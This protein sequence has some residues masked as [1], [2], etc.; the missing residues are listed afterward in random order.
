MWH[1]LLLFVG[2]RNDFDWAPPGLG[3]EV[4]HPYIKHEAL[5]CCK[6]CGGGWKHGIH[7]KP[8]N[9]RR[10]AEIMKAEQDRCLE[11][12]KAEGA[13]ARGVA[14]TLLH[15]LPGTT[16][17]ASEKCQ[18][19]KCGKVG[20]VMD[21][22]T[23]PHTGLCVACSGLLAPRSDDDKGPGRLAPP[24]GRGFVERE[25]GQYTGI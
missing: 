3:P 4:N 24:T 8:F 9:E 5:R 20:Y 22:F 7:Q 1:R 11:Y 13:A 10:A 21:E 18:C 19:R 23:S 17:R 6:Y 12:F 15:G 25:H 2:I 14:E 16:I